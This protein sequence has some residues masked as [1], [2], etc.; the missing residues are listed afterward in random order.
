MQILQMGV[1]LQTP[2]C[3]SPAFYPKWLIRVMLTCCPL[4]CRVHVLKLSLMRDTLQSDMQIQ[5]WLSSTLAGRFPDMT[6]FFKVGVLY[7]RLGWPDLV[8][9]SKPQGKWALRLNVLPLLAEHLRVDHISWG[10]SWFPF[11]PSGNFYSRLSLNLP[12]QGITYSC[13]CL[14]LHIQHSSLSLPAAAMDICQHAHSSLSVMG[15]TML[16]SYPSG[17]QKQPCL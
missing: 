2:A 13:G 6:H 3:G 9:D 4:P 14:V 16:T 1:K 10:W 12:V 7:L 5:T 15:W 8:S 11:H 17:P